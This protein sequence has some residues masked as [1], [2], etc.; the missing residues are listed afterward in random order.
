MAFNVNEFAGALK[1]GGARPSL[2]QVQITNPINGVA[3]IQ[4]PFMC[5]AAS[6]PAA[7]M[8]VL[9]APYFGR[10]IKLS[11]TRTYADWSTTI[12]ND[13]DF[14]IRNAIEQWS[15]AIN[16]P[17]GNLNTIGGSSP[18]L[19]KANAQVTQYAKTGEIL[20]VYEFVGIW[21]SDVQSIDLNWETDAIQEFACTWTYDYWR[22]IGGSTGN[23]GGV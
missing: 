9:E 22:V 17:Q 15:H 8:S 6:I 10:R 19:Y 14:A 21:P 5:R 3:D 18:S 23:A 20:R 2:F 11:G 4:V 7:T 13:E 12:M 16:S 1:S